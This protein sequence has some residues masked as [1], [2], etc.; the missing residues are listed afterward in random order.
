M[1][2]TE[3]DQRMSKTQLIEFELRGLAAKAGGMLAPAS[4][5]EFAR[6]PKTALHSQF[7]WDDTDA[8]EAWRL[9]EARNIIR[10]HVTV[11]HADSEPVRVFTSLRP[12]RESNSGYRLTVDVLSN[13][14]L[15]AQML[16]DAK[17][18]L[19]ATKRK[20]HNLQ[21]LSSVWDAIEQAS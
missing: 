13:D 12:D 11:L 6:D 18:E 5:V 15:R 3:Q 1:S 8:A 20:Y 21:E 14:D 4:V 10:V 17:A 2:V 16:A 9:H 19:Q 7:T